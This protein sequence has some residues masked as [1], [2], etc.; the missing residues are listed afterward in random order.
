M[1]KQIIK[2]CMLGTILISSSQLFC[3]IDDL[4]EEYKLSSTQRCAVERFCKEMPVTSDEKEN[5]GHVVDAVLSIPKKNLTPMFLDVICRLTKGMDGKNIRFAIEDISQKPELLVNIF[6]VFNETTMKLLNKSVKS[7]DI[8]G[9]IRDLPF[10]ESS[11]WLNEFIR[12]V[13]I[14]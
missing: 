8:T 12:L 2:L 6:C 1:N 11:Q 14:N 7:D 10:M 4:L 9:L 5:I 3:E 13:E